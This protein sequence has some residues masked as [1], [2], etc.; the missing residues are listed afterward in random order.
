MADCHLGAYRDS[1]LRRLNLVSFLGAMDICMSENVDFIL[2][3][4]D[5]LDNNLPDSGI[6]NEAVKKLREVREKGMRIYVVY[7]SHDYSPSKTSMIDILH[8][9]GLFTK[10]GGDDVEEPRLD[11]VTDHK[12]GAKIAGMSAKRLGLESRQMALMDFSAVEN[13]PGFKIF[14]FHSA[15]SECNPDFASIADTLSA[16]KLPEKFSYYA[17]GHVHSR[18]FGEKNGRLIGFPGPTF[19]SDYRDLETAARGEKKGFFIVDFEGE[20]VMGC[21]FAEAPMPSVILLEYDCSGKTSAAAAPD[22]ENLAASADVKG[23]IILLKVSGELSSGKPSEIDFS[24]IR[25]IMLQN[26]SVSVY[27]NRNGLVSREQVEVR[28]SG[29][30]RDEIESGVFS[31]CLKDYRPGNKELTERSHELSVELLRV[32][33]EEQKGG[34]KSDYEK[35]VLENCLKVMG[36]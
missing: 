3:A 20:S 8:S 27:I 5:L 22:I 24:R 34:T 23:R 18:F 10:V 26:G 21:K 6:L 25:D 32:L 17:T 28:A 16:E 4:G 19:G 7:G 14:M 11:F 12:T 30:T 36:I 9:A 31:S 2:I 29:E 15:I 33:K 35:K 13:E 1:T